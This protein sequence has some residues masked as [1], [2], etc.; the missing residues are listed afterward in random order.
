MDRMAGGDRGKD[1]TP[2]CPDCVPAPLQRPGIPRQQLEPRGLNGEELSLRRPV[3]ARA[4]GGRLFT[5]P[6]TPRAQLLPRVSGSA[7]D[8]SI[9]GPQLTLWKLLAGFAAALGF[10]TPTVG[11]VCA[12]LHP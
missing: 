12:A 7:D 8:V 1:M 6:A 9:W 2:G 10:E 11:L 4:A 5:P 3:F